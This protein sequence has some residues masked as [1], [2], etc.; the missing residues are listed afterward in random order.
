MAKICN[1]R[2][3]LGQHLFYIS[4][5]FLKKGKFYLHVPNCHLY[6]NAELWPDSCC[7]FFVVLVFFVCLVKV[8]LSINN[9]NLLLRAYS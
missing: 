2:M 6:S 9:N 7:H 1:F 4:A 5:S 8:A 3:I